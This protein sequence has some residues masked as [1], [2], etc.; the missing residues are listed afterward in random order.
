MNL[1]MKQ[2]W[3]HRHRGQTCGC[4]GGG[5]WGMEWKFGVSSC[6]LLSMEWMDNGVLLYG[7][8]NYGQYL[9]TNHNGKEYCKKNVYINICIT[10]SL[11]CAAE[12]NTT[13]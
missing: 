12:I 5:G 6:K 10:E 11:C 2:K 4:Q 13:L 9:G 7:T 8:G 3:T 1:S